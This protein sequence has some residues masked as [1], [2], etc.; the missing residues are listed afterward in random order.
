MPFKIYIEKFAKLAWHL[1]LSR[2]TPSCLASAAAVGIANIEPASH[3]LGS[4]LNQLLD[5]EKVW[6][7]DDQC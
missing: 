6:Q 3:E 5:S 1:K 4:P 2:S 7:N